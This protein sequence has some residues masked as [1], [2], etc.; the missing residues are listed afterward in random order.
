[1][2]ASWFRYCL[3]CMHLDFNS[4]PRP[5]QLH[6]KV[7]SKRNIPSQRNQTNLNPTNQST[8]QPIN[9]STNPQKPHLAGL[10][11]AFHTLC[12]LSST[13]PWCF[14]GFHGFHN[15]GPPCWWPRYGGLGHRCRGHDTTVTFREHHSGTGRGAQ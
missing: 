6:K 8:N 3:F 4:T 5:F 10:P 9:Q 13:A 15:A 14:N 12:T 1:M 2:S 7:F 11:C